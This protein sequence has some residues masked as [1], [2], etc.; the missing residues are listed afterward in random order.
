M[1]IYKDVVVRRTD[2]DELVR[3]D[4]KEYKYKGKII[5]KII[6]KGSK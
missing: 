2:S 4:I 1:T 3:G 5:R 6:R